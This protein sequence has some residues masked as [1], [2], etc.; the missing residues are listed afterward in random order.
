MERPFYFRSGPFFQLFWELCFA[1]YPSPLERN[2]PLRVKLWLFTIVGIF[3]FIAGSWIAELIISLLSVICWVT[4]TS[5]FIINRYSDDI[6]DNARDVVLLLVAGTTFALRSRSFVSYASRQGRGATLQSL[7]SSFIWHNPVLAFHASLRLWSYCTGYSTFHLHV[8]RFFWILLAPDFEVGSEFVN[9][10]NKRSASTGW[11]SSI[12]TWVISSI[13]LYILKKA[14][15]SGPTVIIEMCLAAQNI[16]A[17][18][19]LKRPGNDTN[20]KETSPSLPSRAEFELQMLPRLAIVGIFH[21]LGH[22]GLI[23]KRISLDTEGALDWIVSKLAKKSKVSAL[24]QALSPGQRQFRLLTIYPGFGTMSVR[25]SLDWYRLGFAPQYKTI[26]YAWGTARD[27]TILREISID[28]DR[29]HITKSVFE[30]L[31]IMRCSY[32]PVTIWID[33]LCIN[34]ADELEKDSQIPLMPR[35]YSDSSEVV[36]WLGHS[37]T[38]DLAISLIDRLFLINRIR[39]PSKTLYP[40]GVSTESARALKRMFK[41]RWFGRVWVV[42]EI[43]RS[44]RKV[45]IKYGYHSISWERLCWF[46]QTLSSDINEMHALS[47]QIGYSGLS[48]TIA[49]RNVSLIRR[50]TL[51]KHASL[52][53]MF[54]LAQMFRSGT[55]FDAEKPEDRIYGILG[56]ALSQNQ[57]LQPDYQIPLPELFINLVKRSI[58]TTTSDNQLEFLNHAGLGYK[59]TIPNLP[60]WV[61]DWTIKTTCKP[62]LGAQGEHELFYNETAI[63]EIEEDAIDLMTYGRAIPAGDTG[64]RFRFGLAFRDQV[65]RASPWLYNATPGSKPEV[66][67]LPGN[68]LE[69]EGCMVDSILV[70]GSEYPVLDQDDYDTDRKILMEWVDLV[71]QHL[72]GSLSKLDPST[73][74]QTFFRTLLHG[75][76]TTEFDYS[77]ASMPRDIFALSPPAHLEDFWAALRESEH[78]KF[79]EHIPPSIA[80]VKYFT[81]HFRKTC[82]GR[83]F[84][85][86]KEGSMGLF[87]PDSQEGDLICLI[88]GARIPFC[89]RPKSQK[90]AKDEQVFSLI[91]PVYVQGIMQGYPKIGES[92]VDRIKLQ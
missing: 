15:V 82:T 7:W 16:A 54:Y 19:T 84:G 11:L 57:I 56:L 90:E 30:V 41:T 76:D 52:S 67:V 40:Y 1:T 39:A 55:R 53:L 66:S 87:L 50:F 70:I 68:V 72:P 80:D 8:P 47:T 63:H 46:T 60:S 20:L 81:K 38:A 73:V 61:P 49:L 48:D 37:K 59:P 43:V 71:V 42:Q 2:A 75:R 85:I 35:I 86:T 24:Q 92:L 64:A 88:S 21:F 36:V 69:V 29:R 25:C 34:Q 5:S 28:G 18:T 79:L 17:V 4:G 10:A 32:K 31:H 58:E 22:L 45:T 3:E 78:D 44:S 26:S 62:F 13:G 27:R 83:C 9:A 23:A 89:I 91:G 12:W 51:I 77:F 33:Y 14:V 65:G 74:W 6:Y